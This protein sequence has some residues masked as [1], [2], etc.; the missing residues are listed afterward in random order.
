MCGLSLLTYSCADNVCSEKEQNAV[1][2]KQDSV[3]SDCR[4]TK[5]FDGKDK[6]IVFT[7]DDM[8]VHSE[9]VA[10]IF[11]KYHE[12][13]TFYINTAGLDNIKNRIKHPFILV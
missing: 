10:E 1:I 11:D 3:L 8:S 6:A 4:I 9:E 5:W 7:W 13:A 2:V 12:P